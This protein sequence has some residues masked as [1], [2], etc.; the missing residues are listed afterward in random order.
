[1]KNPLYYEK[2][3]SRRRGG[4]CL[5]A[6]LMTYVGAALA[7]ALTTGWP[8]TAISCGICLV[9]LAAAGLRLLALAR[10]LDQR[11]VTEDFC[12]SMET[13]AQVTGAY[14]ATL[15]SPYRINSDR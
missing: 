2:A 11:A 9:L 13:R 14:P 5:C 8:A 6:L 3:A 15:S 12:R 1:M 7:F 10:R 4:A